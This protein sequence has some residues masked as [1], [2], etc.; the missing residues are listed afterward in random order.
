MESI[1]KNSEDN[2]FRYALGINGNNPLVF[3]GINPST[4]TPQNYDRTIEKV[5]SI[6]EYNK[7]DSWIML[8]IYPQRATEP[9]N[10]DFDKNETEHKINKSCI[11]EIL[12][13]KSKIVAAWGDNISIRPYLINCLI[14]ILKEVS[15]KNL[16]WYCIGDLTNKKNPRHPLY[17]KTDEKLNKFDIEHYIEN[18]DER[19]GGV[20]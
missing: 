11:K 19:Y 10:L 14:E 3:F 8:N 2:L 4:A 6:T 1:Y 17:L 16:D 15:G 18:Y 12:Q 5:I 9:V 7:Y 13:E 20:R